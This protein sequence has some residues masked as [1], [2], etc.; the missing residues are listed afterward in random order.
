MEM[1]SRVLTP[2]QVEAVVRDVCRLDVQALKPGNVSVY[3]AGHGMT[4]EDFTRSADIIA[5]L[6]SS[7]GLS[8][9]ERVLRG[10]QAT[11][12]AV[13]CNTNLGIVLLLAPLIEAALTISNSVSLCGR[14]K[15][16]LEALTVGDAEAAYTAIRSANPG[17][18]GSAASQDVAG[19]PTVT[20]RA[21]MQLA[22]ERDRVAYQYASGY[23]DVFETGLPAL[24]AALEQGWSEEWATVACYLRYAARFPDTHITRKSGLAVAE[25]VQMRAKAVE[26]RFKACDNSFTAVPLLLSFDKELKR[27]G[28]NPGT[29]AD[30]TVA[31]LAACRFE[32]LLVEG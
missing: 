31:T 9:G 1:G 15:I 22:A 18:L 6:I 10:V 28:F 2:A 24:R 25:D 12:A 3:S 29:S 20:L 30:L 5:P 14:L 23:E 26:S 13:G 21:A 16:V 8:V 7:C 17:G 19:P 11:M 4:V 32:A 27:G